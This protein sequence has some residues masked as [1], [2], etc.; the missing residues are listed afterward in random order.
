MTATFATA[1][2]TDTIA[3]FFAGTTDTVATDLVIDELDQWHNP[4]DSVA[5]F[6]KPT[7]SH[8]AIGAHQL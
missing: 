4:M 7:F 8:V 5:S 3:T 1:T 2:L 6:S